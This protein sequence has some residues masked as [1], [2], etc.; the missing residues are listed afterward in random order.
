MKPVHRDVR[1]IANRDCAAR[2]EKDQPEYRFRCILTT[3]PAGKSA[4]ST[5]SGNG[6]NIQQDLL[7][8]F[9]STYEKPSSLNARRSVCVGGGGSVTRD[10]NFKELLRN[11]LRFTWGWAVVLSR[12]HILLRKYRTGWPDL[13]FLFVP[14]MCMVRGARSKV[15]L[16]WQDLRINTATQND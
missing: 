11:K 16:G 3:Q 2:S 1:T 8:C 14:V 10:R 12:A 15:S 6:S 7:I 9:I 5:G 4:Q 13:S